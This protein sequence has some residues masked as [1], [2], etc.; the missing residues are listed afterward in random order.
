MV[1]TYA[2]SRSSAVPVLAGQWTIGRCS[3]K[4]RYP[5]AKGFIPWLAGHGHRPESLD[6]PARVDCCLGHGELSVVFFGGLV[7]MDTARRP[8]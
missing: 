3:V 2:S 6:R 5:I 8:N 4:A 1:N 7:G